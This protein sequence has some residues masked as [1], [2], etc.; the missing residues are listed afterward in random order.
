MGRGLVVE[1]PSKIGKSTAV[2]KIL[3]DL[4]GKGKTLAEKTFLDMNVPEDLEKLRDMLKIR[5]LS[6]HIVIDD[7]QRL[8]D[9][10][11]AEL[12]GFMRILADRA[13]RTTKITLIGLRTLSRRL[14]ASRPDLS[15]RY[16]CIVLERQPDERVLKLIE[17]AEQAARLR[18]EHRAEM[19]NS[20]LGSFYLA[21]AICYYTALRSN[22]DDVPDHLTLVPG[23]PDEVLPDVIHEIGPL[24]EEP[25]YRFLRADRLSETPGACFA[26]LHLAS[27]AFDGAVSRSEALQQ[28][29]LLGPAFEWIEKEHLA[30]FIDSDSDLPGLLRFHA[31]KLSILDPLVLYYLRALDWKKAGKDAGLDLTWVNERPE[32]ILPTRTA[33]VRISSMTE[34]MR[35]IHFLDQPSY[36]WWDPRAVRLYDWLVRAYLKPIQ[37]ELLGEKTGIDLSYWD[38]RG[39]PI[40][41]WKG[42]L[43]IAASQGKLRALVDNVLADPSVAAYHP[44]IRACI[45]P[46]NSTS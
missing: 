34:A 15:G 24:F 31:G 27:R 13:D 3:Q 28:Y 14:L 22:I 9:G 43:D 33:E 7:A 11:F 35:A 26:M 40:T 44:H 17:Q 8:K 46:T 25:I 21:Q 2:S 30:S 1:G 16:D 32:V 10:D 20:A 18:F 5:K 38:G 36:P 12:A 6:G 45:E 4:Q 23:I 41:V 39:S 42:L 19:A 37:M 29:P